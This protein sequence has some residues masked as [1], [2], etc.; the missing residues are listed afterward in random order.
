MCSVA[1]FTATTIAPARIGRLARGLLED[2]FR[3]W[4]QLAFANDAFMPVARVAD[5]VFAI[6]SV[7]REQAQDRVGPARDIAVE[8][9][10]G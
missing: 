8:P 10:G 3:P 2:G 9:T 4:A 5:A 7:I 6:R 1:D